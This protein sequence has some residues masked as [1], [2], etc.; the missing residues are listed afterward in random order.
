MS[1]RVA[2][3]IFA[4]DNVIGLAKVYAAERVGRN[5]IVHRGV[6]EVEDLYGEKEGR[7]EGETWTVTLFPLGASI[8]TGLHSRAY[9]RKV[10]R[11]LVPAVQA[12]RDA[13]ETARGNVSED[14]YGRLNPLSVI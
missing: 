11:S 7:D 6:V 4:D 8:I 10:A 9:A 5:L 1:Y 13:V 14:L 2:D 3:V 12:F